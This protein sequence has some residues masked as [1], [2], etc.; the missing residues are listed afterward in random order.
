[1]THD[2]AAVC[3]GDSA[4]GG[5][6]RRGGGACRAASGKGDKAD[7][8]DAAGGTVRMGFLPAEVLAGLE[9]RRIAALWQ[10]EAP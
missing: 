8:S 10:W 3:V 9:L 7:D 4:A 2:D 6:W 5:L 1:M